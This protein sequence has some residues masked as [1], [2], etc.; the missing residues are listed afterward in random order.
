MITR[1]PA[2]LMGICLMAYWG[3]VL[4]MSYKA[5]K[6]IGQGANLIPPERLGRFLRLIWAP[7]VL[8]WICQPWLFA[9]M[10]R[11]PTIFIPL[12]VHPV[13]LWIS[14]VIVAAGFAFTWTCWKKMGRD[15]RMGIDPAEKTT[16]ISTGP[17]AYV[18]HPIYSISQAM[19]AAT[20]AALPSPAMLLAGIVHIALLQWESRREE[21]HLAKIH[22]EAYQEYCQ[23]V[24]RF[25]PI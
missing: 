1:L 15:W 5:R 19:M 4:R 8:V 17:F 9:L 16:L 12:Y 7:A 20:M 24:G 21:L 10:H 18:R 23:R 2:L 25:L 22:G 3:R 11:A 13:L 14:A 6:R